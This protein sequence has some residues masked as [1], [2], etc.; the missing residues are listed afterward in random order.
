MRSDQRQ[1]RAADRACVNTSIAMVCVGRGGEGSCY[2]PLRTWVHHH[3]YCNHHSV[4]T[5]VCTAVAYC[6]LLLLSV[7]NQCRGDQ[8]AASADLTCKYGLKDSYNMKVDWT[9]VSVVFSVGG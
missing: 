2:H 4:R 5:A 1:A 9:E 7:V 8:D 6:C 3:L